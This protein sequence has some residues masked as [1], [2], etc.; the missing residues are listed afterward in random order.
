[1]EE[2]RGWKPGESKGRW[3]EGVTWGHGFGTIANGRVFQQ[4]QGQEPPDEARSTGVT[5]FLLTWNE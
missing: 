2:Y 5:A 4:K 1:M 3:R